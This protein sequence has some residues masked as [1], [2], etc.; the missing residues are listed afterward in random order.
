MTP[1]NKRPRSSADNHI[2]GNMRKIREAVTV[3]PKGNGIEVLERLKFA[4]RKVD[5][6]L[7]TEVV[8]VVPIPS[9]DAGK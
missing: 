8:G 3:A 7:Q 1:N 9:D 6:D 2:I 4:S 5:T